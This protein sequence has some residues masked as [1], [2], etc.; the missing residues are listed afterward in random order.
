MMTNPNIGDDPIDSRLS[1]STIRQL[2]TSRRLLGTEGFNVE[3][4]RLRAA[5]RRDQAREQADIEQR[6]RDLERY[7]QRTADAHQMP[8]E[9]MDL[10]DLPAD[11]REY[12]IAIRQRGD[13]FVYASELGKAR[14][15]ARDAANQRKDQQ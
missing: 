5:A 10:S 11:V 12:L 4:M 6:R 2:F 1:L 9:F 8:P 3:L 15:A 13:L 7:A 14:E